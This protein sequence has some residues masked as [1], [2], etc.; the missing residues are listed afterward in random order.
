MV[1]AIH[2]YQKA[3]NDKVTFASESK[4]ISVGDSVIYVTLLTY[5]PFQ[6]EIAL[7]CHEQSILQRE[8]PMVMDDGATLLQFRIHNYVLSIYVVHI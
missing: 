1:L 8:D 3:I 6:N 2:C 5:G 7:S 4:I